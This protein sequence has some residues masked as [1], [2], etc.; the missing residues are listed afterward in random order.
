MP[1]SVHEIFTR[2][3]LEYTGPVRWD[4]VKNMTHNKPG[5]Y[6]IS[7]QRD[8]KSKSKKGFEYWI[9]DDDFEAWQTN[10]PALSIGETIVESVENIQTY[11]EQFYHDNESILY[12]GQSST[13]IKSRLKNYY[14]YK[15]GTKG[16]HQGGYWLKTLSFVEDLFVY[17][18][19][20]CKNPKEAEF[21]MLMY[22]AENV[23]GK[24]FYKIENF[25]FYLP[26]ANL[27]VDLNKKHDIKCAI[28]SNTC[29]KKLKNLG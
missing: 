23:S 28:P 19:I 3:S 10:S 5:V 8:P 16:N 26:F 11:L 13:D 27:T 15:L 29:N 12:I 25:S 14:D 9:E 7:T 4:E 21:R 18:T 17:H 6:V 22:F 1:V 20:N 24:S 2:F